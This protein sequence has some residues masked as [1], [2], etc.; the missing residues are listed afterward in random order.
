VKKWHKVAVAVSAAMLIAV[1]IGAYVSWDHISIFWISNNLEGRIG[2]VP[3]PAESVPA[4]TRGAHDWP[5]WRG[6]DLDGRSRGLR[7]SR[8]GR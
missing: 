3:S 2:A 5:A 1:C 6:G 7:P 8:S 4:P